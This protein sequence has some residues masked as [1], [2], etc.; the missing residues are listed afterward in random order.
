MARFYVGQRV[1]VVL[2]ERTENLHFLGREGTVNEVIISDNGD[3]GYGLDIF[4]ITFTSEGWWAFEEDQLEPIQDRPEL[5]S[6][7]A[8]RELGLDVDAVR[9]VTA[10]NTT[11]EEWFI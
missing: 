7:D 6:W 5:S 11:V 3:V 10:E 9:G 4:P 8:L 1:R 2:I